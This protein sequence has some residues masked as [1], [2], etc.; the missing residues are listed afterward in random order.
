MSYEATLVIVMDKKT[1]EEK[2]RY[3][4]N[5]RPA[6]KTLEEYLTPA[7]EYLAAVLKLSS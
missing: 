5:E 4:I 2:E 3:L 7:A 1:G 6:T